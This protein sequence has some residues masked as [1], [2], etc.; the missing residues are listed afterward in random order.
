VAPRERARNG[1]TRHSAIQRRATLIETL[2]RLRRLRADRWLASYLRRISRI[3]SGSRLR[4]Q[5]RQ[6]SRWRSRFLIDQRRLAAW[7]AGSTI[8]SPITVPN[9]F[10]GI[11]SAS[12]RVRAI[13]QHA[14]DDIAA[15]QCAQLGNP[16]VAVSALWR[17]CSGLCSY[18]SVLVLPTVTSEA[19]QGDA[20]QH[21]Y[22]SGGFRD[23]ADWSTDAE[24][25]FNRSAK[26]SA[27]ALPIDV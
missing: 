11:V 27:C 19:E 26:C 25:H 12:S 2:Q 14:V 7:V 17:E 13:R 20:C 10:E 9:L 5:S 8:V 16:S 3:V 21:Q 22:P 4:A 18:S 6:I 15:G 23:R 1:G 24:I